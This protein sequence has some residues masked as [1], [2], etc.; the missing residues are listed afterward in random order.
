M[1]SQERQKVLLNRIVEEYINSA[2]PISSK[3]IE[4]KYHLGVCPATIRNDMAFLTEEGFLSQPHTSAGRVPTDK[5]Y[6][7]F[8]DGL[9]ERGFS[10]PKRAQAVEE[11]LSEETKDLWRMMSHL[12]RFMATV[13]SSLATIHLLERDFFWK[14]GWEEVLKE[15]EFEEKDFREEFT[16]FVKE[17]EGDVK[18]MKIADT[19]EIYIGRENPFKRTKNFSIITAECIFPKEGEGRISLIGP[20]RMPYRKNI[21]L[22]ESILKVFEDF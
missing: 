16:D 18:N 13:S 9:L 15:P 6:R 21:G 20:K 12:S 19:V 2:Q 14:E 8:V 4:K 22:V 17:F 7:F 1:T 10:H 11:M 3:L 5:G